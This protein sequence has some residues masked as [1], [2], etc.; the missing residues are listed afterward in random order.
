M[1]I[2]EF[3]RLSR[4]SPKALRRYD[5]LGLLL[6]SR[7]DPGS[8]YRW[9][10]AGQL[11]QARL[12]AV[13]RQIGMPL[14]QIKM[15]VDLAPA[16]AA[17]Q[18]DAY[19]ACAESDHATR[20]ELACYLVD[21]LNG[22]QRLVRAGPG[23]DNQRPIQLGERNRIRQAVGSAHA[24]ECPLDRVALGRPQGVGDIAVA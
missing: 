19:W 12:V 11:D 21:R 18:V 13:L 15:I 14:A 1:G 17:E 6:P 22:K 24:D 10:S 5:E 20:R 2:G 3:A 7:V 16:A 23:D 9:Y 8:G 4:V